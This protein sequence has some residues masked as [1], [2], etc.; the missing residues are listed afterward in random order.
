[1][2]IPYCDVCGILVMT[3]SDIK[4]IEPLCADCKQGRRRVLPSRDSGRINLAGQPAIATI[5]RAVRE[6]VKHNEKA[7]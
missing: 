4:N 7:S 5:I 3:A 1:M 2:I 6:Q